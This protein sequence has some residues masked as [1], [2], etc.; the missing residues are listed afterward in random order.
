MKKVLFVLLFVI[1]LFCVSCALPEEKVS[2]STYEKVPFKTGQSIPNF[3][4]SVVTTNLV[5]TYEFIANANVYSP[6][7]LSLY[8]DGTAK[9]VK[10]TFLYS[11]TDALVSGTWS[12]EG[13]SFSLNLPGIVSRSNVTLK[14]TEWD[15]EK[16]IKYL[17]GSYNELLYKVSDLTMDTSIYSDNSKITGLWAISDDYGEVSGFRILENGTVWRYSTTYTDGKG[18]QRNWQMS[19]TKTEVKF[20]DK[21]YPSMYDTYSIAKVGDFLLLGSTAYAKVN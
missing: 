21:D 17:A 1:V 19:R 4:D 14:W 12:A 11:S 2:T 15:S 8:S 10:Q 5:G 9:L 18:S 3:D 7:W 20:A 16:L 6:Y 13:N